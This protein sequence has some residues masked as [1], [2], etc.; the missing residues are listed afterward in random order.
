MQS[1]NAKLAYNPALKYCVLGSA[2]EAERVWSMAEH[3]LMDA[4]SSLSPLVFELIMYLKYNAHL[5]TIDDVI[6]SNRRRKNESPAAK[7]RLALQ[8]KRFA[9]IDC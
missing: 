1:G 5:W 9:K 4:R 8:K 7:K 2:A 3:V 6:E